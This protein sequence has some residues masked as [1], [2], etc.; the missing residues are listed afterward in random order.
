[1][2]PRARSGVAS[3]LLLLVLGS[4]A[5]AQTLQI[6]IIDFYGLGRLSVA[7]VRQTL[8]FKEGDSISFAGDARPAF[9]VEAEQRL[10][11]LPGVI[12]ASVNPVCCDAG[13]VIVYVGLEQQG[14]AVTRF[15]DNPTGTVRLPADVLQ[16]ARDLEEA[17]KAAVVRGDVG[18]DDSRGHTLMHDAAA[19]AIQER[20]VGY[21][22][23]DLKAL[24]RVL[25]ESSDAGQRAIAAE[26]L[27]YAPVKQDV[28]PDLVYA[29]QDGSPD[30]RNNAM[31]ALFVFTVM[32]PSR[33]QSPVQ[34]PYDPFIALLNSP[35]WTDRNK[36]SFAL[37]GLSA[38]R[39]PK[40]LEALR[41]QALTSLVEMARWKSEGHATAALTI[42]ARIAGQPDEAAKPGDRERIISAALGR[43]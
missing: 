20:F 25:R 13:R 12:R 22:A 31:R 27:G 17:Q 18:E 41:R 36:S 26:V 29:M 28:V 23:R 42:L 35:V 39:D 15:R 38:A 21:A 43:Q 4:R 11:A 14:Q 3:V 6:G 7:D 2:A 40:L 37:L 10:A 32:V 1:M 34:I 9:L 19:R 30:V 24:T 16:A 5:S 33:S 8:T